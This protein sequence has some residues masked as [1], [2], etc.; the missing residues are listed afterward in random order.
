MPFQEQRKMS[1]NALGLQL[2]LQNRQF[3]HH[4]H[5]LIK[6]SKNVTKR[7]LIMASIL[8]LH[9]TTCIRHKTHSVRS[10][11]SNNLRVAVNAECSCSRN[12]RQTRR[13]TNSLK[14]T[15]IFNLHDVKN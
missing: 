9:I 10:I 1:Q 13:Q 15:R 6:R 2:G 5:Q 14:I 3:H 12:I 8:I 7:T 11:T 4:H